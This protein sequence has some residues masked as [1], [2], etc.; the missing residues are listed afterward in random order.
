MKE[1]LVN[2]VKDYKELPDK[3]KRCSWIPWYRKLLWLITTALYHV[4]FSFGDQSK[5]FYFTF[6]V[7]CSFWITVM[8]GKKYWSLHYFMRD[9]SDPVKFP[10]VIELNRMGYHCY[11]GCE[12]EEGWLQYEVVIHEYRF[13]LF[14]L[15]P[16]S[17]TWWEKKD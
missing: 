14:F 3:W 5:S 13:K 9:K 15:I 7:Y 1:A 10:Q 4:G 11:T 2:I 8:I 16:M 6:R 17:L 12:T